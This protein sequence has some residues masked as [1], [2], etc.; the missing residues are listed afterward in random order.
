MKE[1]IENRNLA[2]VTPLIPPRAVKAKLPLTEAAAN[3]VLRTRRAI[4][5]IIHGRDRRLLVIVGPCSIHDPA[6]AYEY[7]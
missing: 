2:A 3:L 6:A 4:R 7:A 1:K 5:D